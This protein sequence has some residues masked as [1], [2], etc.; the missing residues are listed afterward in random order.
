MPPVSSVLRYG[1][2]F[3]PGAPQLDLTPL[4][5]IVGAVVVVRFFVGLRLTPMS[6]TMAAFGG[7]LWSYLVVGRGFAMPSLAALVVVVS[8][9]LILRDT[10]PEGMPH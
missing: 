2:P 10:R 4:V 6:L 5:S 1:V 3:Y 9:R 7:A 8:L